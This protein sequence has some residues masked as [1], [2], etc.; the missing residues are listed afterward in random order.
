VFPYVYRMQFYSSRMFTV[1]YFDAPVCF[2][3]VLIIHKMV[4]IVKSYKN[5]TIILA[6]A[7][8]LIY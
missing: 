2:P 5:L 4:R 7:I 3:V 6:L 8:N 1:C